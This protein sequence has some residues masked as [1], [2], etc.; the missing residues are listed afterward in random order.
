MSRIFANASAFRKALM[1]KGNIRI[2]AVTSMLT[3]AYVSMLSAVLQPF[4]V[5]GVGLSL[6]ALGVL[7]AVGGRPSGLASSLVQPVS[8][9]LADA[10]GRRVMIV[11]GS[12]VGILSM[13][14]FLAA[15]LSL[16]PAFLAVGFVLFGLSLLGSPASQAMIAESVPSELGRIGIAFS[17]VFFFTQLP[18]AFAPLVAGFAAQAYGYYLIFTAAAV[19]ESFN[20]VLLSTQL[21]ETNRNAVPAGRAGPGLSARR[22]LS[23]P[24]GFTRIFAPFAFDAFFGGLVAGIIY[25]IWAKAFGLT[26]G[27]IG[28][29]VGTLYISVLV[30][31][32]P[33]TRLLLRM[34]PRKTL[35]FSEF[36]TVIAF[37]G[38]MV[39]VSLPFL[40]L[41]SAIFGASIATWVPS[42]QSLIMARAP[43]E[44][45]GS[46]AGKF[47]AFRGIVAFPAPAIGGLLYQAFGYYV[48]VAAA[49]LGET[50]TTLALLWLLPE[51]GGANR[52][53]SEINNLGDRS[54]S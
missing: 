16:S 26:S 46:I 47:A 3:G 44:Q 53:T 34:G 12:V 43:P 20:L 39:S 29:I 40:M 32:Y 4:V 54:G 15:A 28:L 50:F 31:Q 24:P 14:S 11:A 13:L 45:K 25:G 9:T 38:W 8:G 52:P 5:L 41:M 18:G 42:F 2:L 22:L 7:Q 21:K 33:S 48:P 30:W 35:A 1:L 6:P 49:A 36:L 51:L 19:L 10:V 37:A 23:V 27:D 17:V